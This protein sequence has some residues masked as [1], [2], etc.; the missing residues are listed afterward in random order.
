MAR[1][2]G[3]LAVAGAGRVAGPWG[4]LPGARLVRRHRRAALLAERTKGES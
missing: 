2:R 3:L 4:R 1:W